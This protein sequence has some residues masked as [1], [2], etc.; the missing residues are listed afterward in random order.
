[1][2]S[3]SRYL[4]KSS[5]LLLWIL[6]SSTGAALPDEAEVWQQQW[7]AAL[8]AKIA[9]NLHDAERFATGAL[10][11]AER[12]K[13]DPAP[14]SKLIISICLLA[15]IYENQGKFEQAEPLRKRAL[16]AWLKLGPN[17]QAAASGLIYLADVYRKESKYAEAEPLY[18]RAIAILDSLNK[19]GNRTK[20]IELLKH[21]RETLV[22]QKKQAEADRLQKRIDAARDEVLKTSSLGRFAEEKA[23]NAE[24]D[25]SIDRRQIAIAFVNAGKIYILENLITESERV[26]SRAIKAMDQSPEQNSPF[27][28]QLLLESALIH[29]GVPN[30][31]EAE[32]DVRRVLKISQELGEKEESE[33]GPALAMLV[34]L[35]SQENKFDEAE[36]QSARLLKLQ[37][38]AFGQD[39]PKLVN[40]LRERSTILKHLHKDTE[41]AELDQRISALTAGKTTK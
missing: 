17:T 27:M 20:R 13:P 21:L 31:A 35:L 33:I 16:K 28:K 25:N 24:R 5:F 1:M 32:R 36:A 11:A 39:S 26:Y 34:S 29:L 3:N 7:D 30:L 14:D 6:L 19:D 41:A 2:N 22:A 40:T 12:L 10:V 18:T 37:E 8:A 15:D 4:L 23:A 9:N 38:A